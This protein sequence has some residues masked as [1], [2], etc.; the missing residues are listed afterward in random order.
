MI[1]NPQERSW[2]AGA[3]F[4]YGTIQH[5]NAPSLLIDGSGWLGAALLTLAYA[6]V[7]FRPLFARSK[8][9][10][11]MNILGCSLLIAD[12]GWHR[13]WPSA[14]TNVIWGGIAVCGLLR[15][16]EVEKNSKAVE[17]PASLCGKDLGVKFK[18][19]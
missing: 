13:A 5:M 8:A 10:A 17:I 12:T 2:H 1:R 11:C 7:W 4:E 6:L 16:G 14:L 18:E 15:K 9:Y 3:G 19:R